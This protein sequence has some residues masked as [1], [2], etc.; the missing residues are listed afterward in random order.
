MSV[1]EDAGVRSRDEDPE[2]PDEGMD[3]SAVLLLRVAEAD[4][5]WR[6]ERGS[7]LMAR[8]DTAGP[9]VPDV[10]VDLGAATALPAAAVRGLTDLAARHAA[11]GRRLVVVGGPETR[12]VLTLAGA[13]VPAVFATVD[14]AV[15]ALQA[16]GEDPADPLADV[17]GAVARTLEAEPD[18]EGTLRAIVTAAMTHVAGAEYAGISLV[19]GGKVRTVAPTADIVTEI[20]AVQFRLKEGPCVDAIADHGTYRTGDLTQESRWPV[21]GPAAAERGVRSMLC[22]RLF[23]SDNTM[24]A[25]TLYAGRRDAFSERTEQE[26]QLFATHAAIALIGAQKEA[27]LTAAIEHRDTIATA[28][29]ILMARHGVDAAQAFRMLVE[30]SQHANMKLYRVAEW[31]V[32]NRHERAGART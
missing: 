30:A 10:V 23:V 22:Y 1:S 15:H 17:L 18:V 31:L 29:G 7:R 21:F 14:A 5:R 13:A 2:R 26:G 8:L 27:S 20:D 19:A 9:H 24:G 4:L 28:K 11:A 25:L 6:P 3:G 32:D 16:R 12:R